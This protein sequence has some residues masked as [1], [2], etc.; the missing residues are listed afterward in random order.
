[1]IALALLAATALAGK[2]AA[3]ELGLHTVV[4]AALQRGSQV[5]H[6]DIRVQ[7]AEAQARIATGAFD[8]QASARAGWSRLYYPRVESVGGVQVLTDDLQSSW[9]PQI[10]AGAS[11]LFRNG[12]TVQP[13]ITLYPGSGAS[14]AQTFGLTRPQ[15]S[16]NLQVPLLHAFDENNEAA[17]NERASLEEV[18]GSRLERNAA[19]QQAALEMT[20]TYWR[21]LAAAGERQALENNQR[22]LQAYIER[23]RGLARAGQLTPLALEQAVVGQANRDRQ[24]EMIRIAES[25]CRGVLAALLRQEAPLV[26][27]QMGRAFPGMETLAGAAPR[28][29]EATLTDLA[30]RNRP[31]LQALEKYVAA[32]GVRVAGARAGLDPKLNLVIDPNGFFVNLNKSLGG[33]TENGLFARTEAQAR[34]ASLKLTEMKGQIRR[35]IAQGVASL[36]R[37]FSALAGRQK[38]RDMLAQA[39]LEARQAYQSGSMNA[40]TLRLLEEEHADSEVQL[41]EAQ[42]DCAL[43]LAGLRLVTGTLVVEG[44][45]AAARNALLLRSLEF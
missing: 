22:Q 35:D 4:G 14:Q 38:S 1:M 28:L 30:Y 2:A 15:P 39:T 3:Q 20:Q 32:A 34:E 13:G 44:E 36:K 11:K 5:A 25:G 19:R 10:T 26:L 27:P 16:L 29:N 31:D 17:A 8:W 23:Q 41:L 24:L 42:L 12:M 21:C 40:E 6:A 43:D 45:E 9:N 37:S 7:L 33:N 18:D